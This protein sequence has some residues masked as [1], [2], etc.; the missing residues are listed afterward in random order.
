MLR[1][2]QD[3]DE[4]LADLLITGQEVMSHF[5]EGKCERHDIGDK[6]AKQEDVAWFAPEPF[7]PQDHQGHKDVER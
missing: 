3:G 7:Q 2:P 4:H 6:D 1:D 5:E